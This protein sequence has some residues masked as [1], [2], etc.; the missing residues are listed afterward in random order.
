MAAELVLL[1]EGLAAEGTGV[2]PGT[3]VRRQLP[4]AGVQHPARVAISVQKII[5]VQQ[6]L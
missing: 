1:L 6:M 4:G 3:A 5:S 2:G